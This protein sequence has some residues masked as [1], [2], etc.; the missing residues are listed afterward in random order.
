MKL[1]EEGRLTILPRLNSL[2]HDPG[3]SLGHE[4]ILT[5]GKQNQTEDISGRHDHG[6]YFVTHVTQA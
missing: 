2:N 4:D 6:L 3:T 5:F 1:E